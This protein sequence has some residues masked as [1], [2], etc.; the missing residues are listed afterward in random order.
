LF[1]TDPAT[2]PTLTCSVCKITCSSQRK[3]DAHLTT[4]K[5]LKKTTSVC[6]V[7]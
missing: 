3:Y 4:A 5:H 2:R 6:V 7:E 1:R